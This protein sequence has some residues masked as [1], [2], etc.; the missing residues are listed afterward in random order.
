M[1]NEDLQWPR[2]NPQKPS[3]DSNVDISVQTFV[4]RP[5]EKKKAWQDNPI[6]I[7]VFLMRQSE[8]ELRYTWNSVAG[9][10]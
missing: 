2:D 1:A 5:Q 10:R 9:E 8:L 3:A 7:M 4:V 6:L